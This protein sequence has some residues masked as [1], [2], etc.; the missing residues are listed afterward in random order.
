MITIALI[1]LIIKW[2]RQGLSDAAIV[3]KA[4]ADGRLS[5]KEAK[6]LVK[7]LRSNVK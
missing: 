2:I 6:R 1:L 4:T 3:A 7:I 5:E